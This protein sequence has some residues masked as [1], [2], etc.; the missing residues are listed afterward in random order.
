MHLFSPRAEV[1]FPNGANSSDVLINGI[2]FNLTTLNYWNFTL[3][4]NGTLSNG[5]NC[6]L[7]LPSFYPVMLS[8]GT[9]LNA[10]SCYAP[11]FNVS[12]RGGLGVGFACLF[13]MSLMFTLWNLRKHGT[14]YLPQEKRFRAVGRRWQWYWMSFVAACGIISCISAVDVD[15]DYLPSL[16]LILEVFFWYL[17]M[18]GVL[19]TVWEGVRHWYVHVA[20]E[21]IGY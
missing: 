20:F 17:M 12:Q 16:P 8:N 11:Y 10:T 18:P 7:T 14:L 15:R 1:A 3:Y 9:F 4:D 19:A 13:A 21:L 5:S 2:H 6:Y